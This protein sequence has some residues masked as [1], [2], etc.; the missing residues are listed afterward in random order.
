[1]WHATSAAF[2]LCSSREKFIVALPRR[3]SMQTLE[4]EF[5]ICLGYCRFCIPFWSRFGSGFKFVVTEGWAQHSFHIRVISAVVSAKPRTIDA[6]TNADGSDLPI[7]SAENFTFIEEM[8]KRK[9][10]TLSCNCKTIH[11][12]GWSLSN[13]PVAHLPTVT[14]SFATNPFAFNEH[15]T[16][17]SCYSC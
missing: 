15:L 8:K 11:N 16:H 3:S 17:D 7:L 1:M 9:P 4:S 14:D 12:F 5:C 2:V 13:R 10:I 6:L